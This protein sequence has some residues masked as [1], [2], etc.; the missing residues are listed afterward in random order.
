VTTSRS[1]GRTTVSVG[2]AATGVIDACVNNS[3]GTIKIVSSTTDCSNNEIRLVWNGA[4]VAG[5]PGPQGATG[6]TGAAGL[7]GPTGATGPT[8]STG[9]TGLTGPTGATG[10]AG[11]SGASGAVGPTGATGS[12][13]ATGATGATGSQGPSAII[14]RTQ[15]RYGGDHTDHAPTGFPKQL[16]EIGTFTQT[17][18]A[19]T[20]E[21][22]WN[23]HVDATTDGDAFAF[24]SFQIRV[25]GNLSSF[26][27]FGALVFA[28]NL[29]AGTFF[30]PVSTTNIFTGLAAG[31]HTVSLWDEG[32]HV[33]ACE[34]NYGNFA[35]KVI[36]T[37]TTP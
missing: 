10:A 26:N 23:S 31:V 22:V 6:A 33:T 21:I 17:S 36:V 7:V 35:E 14:G 5:Q 2:L 16:R 15:I 30:S 11:P 29:A 28:D 13:G 37:E 27:E 34:D 9:A 4:G 18:S 1:V 19:S 12:N 32:Q 20:I 8:G 25:D 3:S 24:C